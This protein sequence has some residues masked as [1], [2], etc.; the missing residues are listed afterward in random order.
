MVRSKLLILREPNREATV[1]TQAL[2]KDG[3]EVIDA[4]IDFD[5]GQLAIAD[6]SVIILDITTVTRRILDL[7]SRLRNANASATLLVLG[8]PVA[9]AKRIAAL[10]AGSDAYLTKPLLVSELQARIRSALRRGNEGRQATQRRLR[11]AGRAIDFDDRSVTSNGQPVH[12][13]PIE[14]H[15]LENLVSKLNQTVP[16]EELVQKIWGNNSS[17]GV[18]SLRVFIKSLRSKLEPDPKRPRY[19][20]TEPA[21]GYRLQIPD[22]DRTPHH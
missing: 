20:I 15:L 12:L 5:P 18:H 17:K 1:L 8:M 13:T 22:A 21:I 7:C 6:C 4:P 16:G 14:W 19:I 3:C 2:P 11:L 9:E 10:E